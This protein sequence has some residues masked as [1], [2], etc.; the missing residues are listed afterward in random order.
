MFAAVEAPDFPL[1]ALCR[2]EA[3]LADAPVA[4]F[5]GEGRRAAVAFAS[6]P[7]LKAGVGAGMTVAQALAECPALTVRP[8]SPE[9]EA[10]ASAVL[11]AA[12]WQASPRV[13]AT[14]PGLCTLDLAGR[15]LGQFRRELPRLRKQLQAHGLTCRVG[16]AD[17]PLVA[18]FAAGPF[19]LLL[20]QFFLFGLGLGLPV[21]VH[22]DFGLVVLVFRHRRFSLA[23]MNGSLRMSSSI[24]KF[25]YVTSAGQ[26]SKSTR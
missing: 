18:R 10:E 8:P 20:R 15:N 25:S 11:L 21:V 22:D 26:K 24:P 12:C 7:A 5:R 3:E 9:A 16:V 2:L 17:N 4:I 6:V 14:A 13:E 23:S 19:I 1:Q